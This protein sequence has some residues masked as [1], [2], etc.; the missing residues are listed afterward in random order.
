MALINILQSF[1]YGDM[2]NEYIL[3]SSSLYTTY[4]DK[5]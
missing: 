3:H 4:T 2:I 5:N 1:K